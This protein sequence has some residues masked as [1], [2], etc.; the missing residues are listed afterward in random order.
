MDRDRGRPTGQR[1][2]LTGDL[3]PVDVVAQS[4]ALRLR[5][6]DVSYLLKRSQRR[7]TIAF[8]VDEA[9][10]TVHAPWKCAQHRIDAA[11]EESA[12]WI[13]KKIDVWSRIELRT[14][15]W[16]ES[17]V[18]EYLG[19]PLQLELSVQPVLPPPLLVDPQ[20]LRVTVHD[21]GAHTRI[22]DGVVSWYRRHAQRLFA[23]RVSHYAA[24][25]G[26]RAARLSLSGAQTR[27][28]SC[29]AKG[30]VRLNW[31]LIQ[32]PHHVIDYVVVHELAHLVELNHSKRFW[33]I[34]ER[35]FPDHLRAREHLDRRGRWY[36]AI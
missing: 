8:T 16:D 7:R 24:A 19:Q 20:R 21:A 27:W 29:N 31:R 30:E 12:A 11:I 15:R 26:V 33:R 35:S 28:G 4:R 14:L 5:E 17:A 13:L 22:R 23:E 9:G 18:L 25:M 2:D 3:F 10:L 32:A 6:R 1:A 36:L 34:V